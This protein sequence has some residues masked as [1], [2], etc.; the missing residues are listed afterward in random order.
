MYLLY[1]VA[2]AA[3]EQL[4]PHLADIAGIISRVLCDQQSSI[5]PFYAIKTLSEIVFFVGDDALKPVQQTVPQ[6][7]EVIKKLITVDQV[8]WKSCWKYADH[9][10]T[11]K[12]FVSEKTNEN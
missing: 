3:A 4:K 12:V 8:R 11:T 1:T 6:I 5:A 9:L 7:L 2:S 10:K